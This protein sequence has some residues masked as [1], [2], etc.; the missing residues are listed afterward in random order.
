MKN[1]FVIAV[2]CIS[3]FYSCDKKDSLLIRDAKI[4][5]EFVLNEQECVTIKYLP[6][7]SIADELEE[8]DVCFNKV[9]LDT[10]GTP[11]EC[12]NRYPCGY[13]F[14]EVVINQRE[15]VDTLQ[16]GIVN[17]ISDASSNCM[18][19]ARISRPTTLDTLGFKFCLLKL[20]PLTEADQ[21]LATVKLQVSEL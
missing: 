15:E 10:R 21:K 14:V 16:L 2:L 5:Q 6:E 1:L 20:N 12:V 19:D 17:L 3:C 4:G 7:I 8:I 18:N 13:A 9:L 11:E